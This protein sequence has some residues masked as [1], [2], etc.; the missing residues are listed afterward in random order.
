MGDLPPHRPESDALEQLEP[1]L[2]HA[3][4]RRAILGALPRR[5]ELPVRFRS[6]KALKMLDLELIRLR[7][8]A[9][10]GRAIDIGANNGLYTYALAKL[11]HPVDAFEPQ[12]RCASV[13]EAWA[14][15]RVTIHR[16]GLSDS[17]GTLTLKVPVTDGV[18]LTGFATMEAVEG[19]YVASEVPIR[20]LDDFGFRDVTFMKI[21]VEGHEPKVLRGAEATIAASRPVLLVEI[22]LLTL[23]KPDAEGLVQQILGYGYDGIF[24]YED[25]WHPITEF[26]FDR[27][28]Q[29]R[30]DGDMDAPYV[31]NFVFKPATV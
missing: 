9:P 28:Q 29:A 13:L 18:A 14:P 19:E 12:P 7:E 23:P 31:I 1:A 17:E 26:S 25:T 10:P 27:H 6:L 16:V 22:Q 15:K 4:M 8:I 20:R 3:K 11:G 24:L 5:W 2:R 30:L 21:D